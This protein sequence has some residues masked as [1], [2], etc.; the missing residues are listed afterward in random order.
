ME[1]LNRIEVTQGEGRML[2]VVVDASRCRLRFRSIVVWYRNP[3]LQRFPLLL[4]RLF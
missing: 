2:Y 3:D 1:E 4:R